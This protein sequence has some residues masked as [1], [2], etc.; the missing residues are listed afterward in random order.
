MFINGELFFPFGIYLTNVKE[1]DLLLI[2]KTH[3][4]LIL[5]NIPI[6]KKD[7]DMISTTQ[8]GK[9]KVIYA[10]NSLYSFIGRTVS[11]KSNYIPP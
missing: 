1:S 5:P 11:K 2:N 9:I 10:L 3:L 6:S 4:N 8:Q 7:M